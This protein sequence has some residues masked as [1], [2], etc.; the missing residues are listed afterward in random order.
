MQLTDLD[1]K[2]LDGVLGPATQMAMSIVVKM[3][4]I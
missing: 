3:A 2:K 1:Q 4:P